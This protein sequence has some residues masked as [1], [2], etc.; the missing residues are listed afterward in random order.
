MFFFNVNGTCDDGRHAPA[1]G[2]VEPHGSVVDVALLG[3]HPVD[4]ETLHKHPSKR[5]HEEVMQQD[6]N[7]CAQELEGHKNKSD[8]SDFCRKVIIYN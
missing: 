1:D 2:V 4:V 6:G 3:L 5:G 8:I 7:N